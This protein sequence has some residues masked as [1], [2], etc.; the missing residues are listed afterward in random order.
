MRRR[1]RV[2]PVVAVLCFVA[3]SCSG[4]R[5]PATAAPGPV[6]ATV[7]VFDRG[8]GDGWNDYGWAASVPPTGPATL[9]LGEFGGWIIAHPELA[10]T[11][12]SL[13]IRVEAPADLGD[14]FLTVRLSDGQG[15]SNPTQTPR[16]VASTGGTLVAEL[17]VR[18]L[19]DGTTRFDRIV[20]QAA[21]SFPSHTDVRV[22]EV[23][24]RR[25]APTPPAAGSTG[26]SV[27]CTATATPIS[28]HI[29]GL[30][31]RS[32]DDQ[33]DG[34]QW[35]MHP[36]SRRWG[37]NPT[38][39][40]NWQS[41]HWWN[42]A[43]DYFFRNVEVLPGPTPA[44]ETFVRDNWAHGAGSAITVPM[45][46]W[47]AKD[48]RS[49]SFPVG[50]FG[51]EAQTD[52]DVPDAGNGDSPDD[53]H[54]VPLAPGQTSV[55]SDPASIGRWVQSLAELARRNGRPA[56]LMY[57]L[58]NEPELWNDTHRDVR[59]EPLGY[60][61]LLSTS[62][63]Y[64][65]AIRAADPD[66]LIAGP[67]VWGW[68]A[69]TYSGID[70]EDGFDET[71]DHDAHGGKGLIEWY[72]GKMRAASEAAGVRLLDVLDVHFYPQGDVFEGGND[73]DTAARRI[74]AT[75]ALWDPTYRDESWIDAEVDLIDR[76]QRWVDDNYPGTK[77]SLGEYNFGGEDDMSGAL[78]E[79][80]V[81][82]HLGQK[83]VFSA[84][85]WTVP[86]E[87]S[88]VYWAFRAFTDY[89]GAG[90]HFGD[91]SVP[92]RI[93]GER[94]IFASASSTSD[95]KVVV[96]L[97][98]DRDHDSSTTVHLEGCDVDTAEAWSFTG[99]ESG[100][101]PTTATVKDAALSLT[102]APYSVTVVRLRPGAS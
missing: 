16:F 93:G 26:A 33:T 73:P 79:A 97:N 64:A 78:A 75:R 43:S 76:M 2:L 54:L 3:A 50:R 37:G 11:F 24:L 20:L 34:A 68:P 42:T 9:D 77:L 15:R 61:E 70:A 92:A 39:R 10:G 69:Y 52:P 35:D 56:P 29:Y 63:A 28:P 49:Y 86:P 14:S 27:D 101:A 62:V 71:P 32:G 21:R 88:P 12:A 95:D 87:R 30:A 99:A 100:P 98:E 59:T 5:H 38:S 22:V 90:G 57:F 83:G 31:F 48:D 47:V 85:Y 67:S 80:E 82:G 89:D 23:L 8:L 65:S 18:D 44:H 17:A 40:Y 58:D 7:V 46:G 96:L 53:E 36:D 41:G 19:L 60:D 45:L 84:F 81:L 91:L 72:L 55:P 4:G 74:R 13:S 51:A 1:G 6:G 94:S 102:L 25:S 66:A